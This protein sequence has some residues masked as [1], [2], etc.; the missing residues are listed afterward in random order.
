MKLNIQN[1]FFSIFFLFCLHVESVFGQKKLA[2]PK[3]RPSPLAFAKN[4]LQASKNTNISTLGIEDGLS[5]NSVNTIFK[6]KFG[7]MWFGTDDGLNRYDGYEFKIF[8]NNRNDTSSIAYNRITCLADDDEGNIW[9]GTNNGLSIYY[10]FSSK[11]KMPRYFDE[12]Q[13]K[14]IKADIEINSLKKDNFGGLWIATNSKG[15]LYKAPGKALI[16]IS[17]FSN[18][19][20]KAHNIISLAIDSSQVW[21]VMEGVGLCSY[22]I[23]TGKSKLISNLFPLAN[24]LYFDKENH[25]WVGSD[26]GVYK[27]DILLEKVMWYKSQQ[28][29]K[30]IRVTDIKQNKKG[31]ICAATDGGGVYKFDTDGNVID[32]ITSRPGQKNLASNAVT[33]LWFDGEDRSWMGTLR[34]GVNI[35]DNRKNKFKTVSHN[36]NNPNSLINDFVLSFCEDSYGNVWIGTDGGG[37]SIWNRKT[38]NFSNFV[39]DVGN[40]NSLSNNNVT[41]IIEDVDHEIWIGT[42]GGSINKYIPRNKSF[43]SYKCESLGLED[44]NIW[45]LYRDAENNIWA[46]TTFG[47]NLTYK[48]NRKL[49]RFEAIDKRFN[50]V[51]TIAEDKN[52]SLWFGNEGGELLKSKTSR[53]KVSAFNFKHPIRALYADDFDDFWV[54]VQYTGLIYLNGKTDKLSRFTE[55]EGLCNNSVLNILP[56]GKGNLWISTFDGISR[57]NIRSRTFKNFYKADGLQSNQFNYNAALRLKDGTL[58]FGGIRGFNYFNPAEITNDQGFPNL[59]V[60]DLEILNQPLSYTGKITTDSS[61]LATIKNITLPFKKASIDISFAALEYSAPQKIRYAYYLEGWDRKWIY[62]TSNRS[63]YYSRLTEGKYTFHL[64]STNTDGRWNPNEKLVYINILPPWYRSICAYFLYLLALIAALLLY[65]RY[66][67]AK[68]RLEQ[69]LAINKIKTTNEAALNENKLSFFT[70]ISHEFRTP[71]T[72]IINPARD[73]LQQGVNVDSENTIQTIYRNSRRLLSLVDQLLLFRKADNEAYQLQISKLDILQLCTDTFA[74]FVNEAKLHHLSYE[75]IGDTHTEIYVDKEKIEI[76]LFNLLGNAIKYTPNGGT[77]ILRISENEQQINIAVED[78]GVGIKPEKLSKL[79]DKFYQATTAAGNNSSGFGIGLYL[80]KTFISQHRGKIWVTPNHPT[81]SIFNVELKKGN[82]HFGDEATFLTQPPGKTLMDELKH[83][84]TIPS[85]KTIAEISTFRSDQ[86]ITSKKTILIVDD[87]DEM[88]NYLI[89]IF[90]DSYL[91]LEADSGN[92]ALTIIQKELPDL[93]I[94]DVVMDG[95]DGIGLCTAIKTDLSKN[96]IPVILL[97]ASASS[98]VKLR[99]IKGGADDYIGKPFDTELLLARAEMLLKNRADLQNYFFNEILQSSERN[100]ISK[101]E[102][103]FL[104]RCSKVINRHINNPTF[105]IEILVDEIGMSHSNLYK[106]IKASSGH[107]ANGFIRFIRLRKAAEILIYTD[108]LVNEAAMACGINDIK[109]F[110]KHFSNQFGMPPSAFIKK[111]RSTFKDK[112]KIIYRLPPITFL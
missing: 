6:D 68:A 88:R 93:I 107:T 90:K 20:I 46:G 35:I 102:R 39:H 25:L 56:D 95:L 85:P 83:D 82:I 16:K 52:N 99:G 104:S 81:G 19:Q 51:T 79:F 45:K 89:R 60:T 96:H 98:E 22:N 109:Y 87:N 11:F 31:E 42:F 111:H 8:R 94:S 76:V 61:S 3:G 37:I 62:P 34:G 54:G 66:R 10:N 58:L 30:V 50:H 105:S 15:L 71:L 1:L 53:T 86:F 33:S 78:N 44:R 75:L 21:F 32:R 69:E 57:F 13:K 23:S 49:D 43:V 106:K 97:T 103:E 4:E 108:S 5:N 28:N 100:Q 59:L 41:S 2:S 64:K 29:E 18:I 24:C 91:I 17:L 48:L 36:P 92:S 27:Y 70:N 40:P 80:A 47:Q 84:P 74:C 73:L 101:E 67:V 65:N 14:Y 77:I 55:T 9:V 112:F 26:Q 63:A 110:R 72:L 38:N 7:Y 12:N